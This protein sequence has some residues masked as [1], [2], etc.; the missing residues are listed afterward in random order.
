MISENLSHDSKVWTKEYDLQ[1]KLVTVTGE[2]SK[3][4][5]SVFI[6]DNLPGYEYVDITY[7][8][9][10]YVR[11]TPSSAA[12]KVKKGYKICRFAQF[13]E[14]KAIMPAILQ[15]LLKARKSTRKL[16]PQQTHLSLIHI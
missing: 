2:R 7:D 8:T 3:D 9:Y 6:Y 13:P 5:A 14:G 15:E 11:K 10:K 12:I 4:D 1:G 16:I